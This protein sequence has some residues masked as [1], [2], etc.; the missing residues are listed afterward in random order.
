M[1]LIVSDAGPLI[2]LS[3]I[4]QLELLHKLFG[5]IVV[6]EMVVRELRLDERRPGVELLAQAIHP[7]NWIESMKSPGSRALPGLG[8]GESAAIRLAEQLRC[9]LLLDERRARTV[10]GMRG[11]S[12]L[13]TGRVLLAAKQKHLIPNIGDVLNAL[14]AAGYRL[15]DSLCSRLLDL[16]GEH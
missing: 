5:R 7:D 12:I 13:G 6:P 15:S 2:A 10:A 14:K 1:S 3:R 16:A 9:P 11:L 4:G 8:D